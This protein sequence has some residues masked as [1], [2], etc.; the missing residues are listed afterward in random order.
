MSVKHE[1]IRTSQAPAPVGH[2][3][4]GVKTTIHTGR[5]ASASITIQLEIAGQLGM[6]RNG[7]MV[8]GGVGAETLQALK[9][10]KEIA[11][12]GGALLTDVVRTRILVASLDDMAEVNRVYADFFGD[13]TPARSSF[14]VGVPRQGR[15]EIEAMAIYSR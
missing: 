14:A 4:Q 9:N 2:Y 1:I 13:W 6:L 12:A 11:M 8:A 7:T 3:A 5:G 15:V 10:I